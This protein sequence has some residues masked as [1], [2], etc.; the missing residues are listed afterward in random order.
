MNLDNHILN[1]ADQCVK[2]GMCLPHC[3]TY[4][5]TQLESESPRGRIA[6]IQGLISNKITS[7]KSALAHIDNCLTCR[8]CEKICPSDV[9][10]GSL[11]DEF[12]TRQKGKLQS[13]RKTLLKS[14]IRFVLLNSTLNS[15][16]VSSAKILRLEKTIG[17]SKPLPEQSRNIYF[18]NKTIYPTHNPDYQ[19]KN[20][21]VGLF[22]GCTGSSFDRKTLNDVIFVLNAIGFEVKIS[23]TAKCCGALDSHA[24]RAQSALQLATENIKVFN[25]L[26]VDHII[27]FA[28]GCGAQLSEYHLINWNT[29]EQQESAKLFTNKLSEVSKFIHLHWPSSIVFDKSTLSIAVHE[30]CTHRNVLR[31]SDSGYL[32]LQRIPGITIKPLQENKFCC[33]AAGD[34]MMTHKTMANKLRLPKINEL[35]QLNPNLLLTTNI[36]CALHLRKGL[37]SAKLTIPVKHPVSLIADLMKKT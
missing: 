2:C 15:W 34:Y 30:P 24:G 19:T 33:G 4:L 22:I 21:V 20:N 26:N 7:N 14:L 8:A 5:A 18:N 28:S 3:P 36:G 9:S 6:I 25:N 31:E 17:L 16:I 13:S 10:Y 37:F 35:Q 12:K 27:Y 1:L 29:T 23:N 32:L 11:L